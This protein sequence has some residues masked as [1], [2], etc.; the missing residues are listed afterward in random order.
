MTAVA[1]I[2]ESVQVFCL[3]VYAMEKEDIFV[4]IPAELRGGMVGC[5]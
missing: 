3:F 1:D 2:T 4:A 5:S